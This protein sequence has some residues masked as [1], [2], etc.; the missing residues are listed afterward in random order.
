M[1]SHIDPQLATLVDRPPPGDGW[2]FEIK[3]DGYRL[4]V[5]V[6]DG[7]V[8]LF[9]RNGHDWTA[10]MPRL[11]DALASLAVDNV[12]MD[13]EAVVLDSSGKPDFN[14][15]QNAFDRRSTAQITLFVFDLL[16]L[17]GADLREQP[18]RTR[19][20]LLEKLMSESEDPVLRF[21]EDFAEDPASLVASACKMQLEGIIGKRNDAPYR[22]GRSKDWIKLKCNRRQEFVVGGFSRPRGASKGLDQLL[23]GVFERDGSLRYVGTVLP[24]LKARPAAAFGKRAESLVR[25]QPQFHNAPR[26][27][28]GREFVWLEPEL[29]AEVAF[30]EWTPSGELRH[31]SFVSF[32]DDKPA[33]SITKEIVASSDRDEPAQSMGSTRERTG[34]RGSVILHGVAIS[35][36]GRLMDAASGQTKIDVARYYD[37]IAEWALPWLHDRPVTLVRAPQGIKGELFFQK[38][39]EKMR[40]PGVS[41]LPVELHPR[42]PPLLVANSAE[43]LVGLAQMGVVVRCFPFFVCLR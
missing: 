40:I 5:R 38:H 21:S 23:L 35:N 12:W 13:A 37:R 27:E 26:P 28:K 11:R 9:T 18:L 2:S 34:P 10:R 17:N 31:A 22:S 43:A 41:E 4:M 25:R 3:F 42:H 32:R 1:P 24:Y 29:V 6:E 33:A 15:L 14:A 30:L 36:P 20:A 39:A 8:S 16:Y 19:R 7:R